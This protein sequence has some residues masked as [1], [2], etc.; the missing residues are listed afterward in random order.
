MDG[1]RMGGRG[2]GTKN[3]EKTKIG[4]DL[5]KVICRTQLSRVCVE[6]CMLAM[7]VMTVEQLLCQP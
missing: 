5:Y 4:N 3:K 1:E 2:R 7:A 6:H